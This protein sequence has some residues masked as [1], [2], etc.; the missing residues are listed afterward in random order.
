M[1]VMNHIVARVICSLMAMTALTAVVVTVV[2]YTGDEHREAV[3]SIAREFF[4]L[5]ERA[6]RTS[7][8]A[9]GTLVNPTSTPEGGVIQ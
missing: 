3:T 2:V 7:R 8:A 5:V 1:R 9:P 6:S 4:E